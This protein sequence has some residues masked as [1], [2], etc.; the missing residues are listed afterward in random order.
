M[1]SLYFNLYRAVKNH[2]I[3][4][5]GFCFCMDYN[6]V[7]YFVESYQLLFENKLSWIFHKQIYFYDNK[8]NYF[9]DNLYIII[10]LITVD[11]F[12]FVIKFGVNI[13]PKNVTTSTI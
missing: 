13:F 4:T 9:F 5:Y 2:V 1:I 6:N 8:K 11:T 12:F 7:S 10:K 3:F